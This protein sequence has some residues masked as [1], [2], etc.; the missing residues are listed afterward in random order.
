M[1][2]VATAGTKVRKKTWYASG[3]LLV[4][5]L[6]A[7][8][9]CLPKR[10]GNFCPCETHE[11]CQ[12]FTP[13]TAG[14]KFFKDKAKCDM[15]AKKCVNVYSEGGCEVTNFLAKQKSIH[16]AVEGL[17]SRLNAAEIDPQFKIDAYKRSCLSASDNFCTNYTRE[18]IYRNTT[19]KILVQNW[20]SAQMSAQLVQII[21]VEVLKIPTSLVHVIEEEGK[22]DDVVHTKGFYEDHVGKALHTDAPK[23]YNLKTVEKCNNSTN[24]QAGVCADMMMEVWRT[25]DSQIATAKYSNT[26]KIPYGPQGQIGLYVPRWVV[27]ENPDLASYRGFKNGEIQRKLRNKNLFPLPV[28]WSDYCTKY[29]GQQGVG[30]NVTRVCPIPDKFQADYSHRYYFKDSAGDVLYGGYFA[31]GNN[32]SAGYLSTIDYC[33]WGEYSKFMFKKNDLLIDYGGP[34]NNRNGYYLNDMYDIPQ[35]AK[36]NKVG[37]IMFWWQPEILPVDLKASDKRYEMVRIQFPPNT[38]VCRNDRNKAYNDNLC[39]AEKRIN[40]SR[41]D[42]AG[43]DWAADPL[44]K[45]VSERMVN[46]SKDLD[47]E[48]FHQL[49]ADLKNPIYRLMQGFKVNNELLD[50]MFRAFLDLKKDVKVHKDIGQIEQMLINHAVCKIATATDVPKDAMIH[51]EDMWQQTLAG[52]PSRYILPDVKLFQQRHDFLSICFLIC[53]ILVATTFAFCIAMAVLVWKHKDKNSIK[54]AQPSYTMVILSGCALIFIHVFLSLMEPNANNEVAGSAHCIASRFCRHVGIFATIVPLFVILNTITNIVKKSSKRFNKK[55]GQHAA[56]AMLCKTVISLCFINAYCITWTLVDS[57]RSVPRFKP[58]QKYSAVLKGENEQFLVRTECR[59]YEGNDPF[60]AIISTIEG[61]FLVWGVF[62]AIRNGGVR[63]EFN[64]SK[65]VAFAMYNA[66]FTMFIP[67]LVNAKVIRFYDGSTIALIHAMATW[68][69]F[70]ILIV[71]YYKIVFLIADSAKST[72]R[73]CRRLV[74]STSSVNN[75]IESSMDDVETT[76]GAANPE[77]DAKQ[78]SV[79]VNPI[80]KEKDMHL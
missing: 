54:R 52:I 79:T 58:V 25:I 64:T 65:P 29:V 11:D 24:S 66:G 63:K 80:L 36:E 33:D 3:V 21:L 15:E 56:K 17:Q 45:V 34:G 39:E 10:P 16:R 46:N 38:V 62:T 41:Y 13:D 49:Q 9:A 28:S 32:S 71:F 7:G 51:I 42:N 6:H 69:I 43:C 67:L 19:L 78:V 2:H 70:S 61:L 68:W 12:L 14:Y 57:I 20:L 27:D 74:G 59:A 76:M 30:Y 31:S 60:F 44:R 73:H 50:Q 37:F 40:S 47:A 1:I 26:R 55:R 77:S 8:Y 23:A 18:T 53:Q 5:C 4:A 22:A 35:A 72:K 75:T 48:I